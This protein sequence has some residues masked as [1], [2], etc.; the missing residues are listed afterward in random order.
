MNTRHTPGPLHV[1][2]DK[3]FPFDLL[4]VDATGNII[5]RESRYAYSTKQKT[6]EDVMTGRYLDPDIRVDAVLANE[7]QLADMVLRAAAP[8]L[9]E[10][11]KELILPFEQTCL[12][13]REESCAVCSR[14]SSE[15]A[16]AVKARAIIAK[17]EGKL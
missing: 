10:L 4:L 2:T 9:L 12:C 11:I 1:D 13:S 17:A 3:R 15:F 16:T 14:P 8:E 5:A 7:R 6:V